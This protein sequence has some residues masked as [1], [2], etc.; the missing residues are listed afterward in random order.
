MIQIEKIIELNVNGKV[1]KDLT[2][3]P[4]VIMW[5]EQGDVFKGYLDL[6]YIYYNTGMIALY[7]DE[8]KRIIKSN[9]FVDDLAFI[10]DKEIK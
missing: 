2:E 3:K 8:G 6:R 9:L 4:R 1:F 7:N 10:E 5:T